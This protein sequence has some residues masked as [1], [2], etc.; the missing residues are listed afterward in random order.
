MIKLIAVDL[1]GTFL[2]DKK[3]FNEKY[4]AKLLDLMKMQGVQFVVCTGNNP[5]RVNQY[6]KNFSNQYD[7]IANNGGQIYINGER[8]TAHV[9]PTHTLKLINDLV[10]KLNYPI[11]RGLLFTSINDKAW[12]PKE[13]ENAELPAKEVSN[14][15]NELQIYKNIEEINDDAVQ[16]SIHFQENLGIEEKFMN[17]LNEEFG[18]LVTVTTSGYGAVDVIAKG[19][20]KA[21]ALA[22]MGSILNIKAEEMAAFGDNINDLEMLNFVGNPYCMI[23]GNEKMKKQ[24]KLSLDDNNNDGVLKTIEQILINNK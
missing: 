1:D 7:L 12:I 19:V 2:N 9:L 13:H 18:E 22:E 23:N 17:N 4:F 15:F 21:K 14:F 8:K 6:F 16:A 10:L 3:T 24:F 5:E 20:N 11:Y